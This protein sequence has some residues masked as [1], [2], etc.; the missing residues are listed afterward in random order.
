MDLAKAASAHSLSWGAPLKRFCLEGDETAL[1]EEIP[2]AELLGPF[3]TLDVFLPS[4]S[5]LDQEHR[6]LIVFILSRHG[7]VGDLGRWL[8]KRL[9]N[10]KEGEDYYGLVGEALR[11]AGKEDHDHL[12]E[13]AV[14]SLSCF[15]KDGRPNSVGRYLQTASVESLQHTFSRTGVG[16]AHDNV[17]R[18]NY[19]ALMQLAPQHVARALEAINKSETHK[20]KD[21]VESFI[22]FYLEVNPEHLLPLA[23]RVVAKMTYA[24][25]KNMYMKRIGRC[26]KI[27]VKLARQ[28]EKTGTKTTTKGSRR[29]RTL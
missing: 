5:K 2:I 21:F 26:E 29:G 7:C 10:E 11:R 18:K 4:Y 19:Q 1:L 8:R 17:L 16:S 20:D 6:R 13:Y 3:A 14:Q 9:P 23:K 22:W 15:R 28:R 24:Y 12:T 25:H 27:A